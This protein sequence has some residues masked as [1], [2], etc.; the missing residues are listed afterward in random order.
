MKSCSVVP[1]I[2]LLPVLLAI[3]AC[4]EYDVSTA[5]IPKPP[6]TQANPTMA[7]MASFSGDL[8]MPGG[9]SLTLPSYSGFPE[10]VKVTITVSGRVYVWSDTRADYF[11][12]TVNAGPGG[13]WIDGGY[14]QCSVGVHIT[15]GNAGFGP[16]LCNMPTNPPG[17]L[18]YDTS[19]VW[20]FT[21]V[22]YGN[23]SATRTPNIPKYAPPSIC[24]TI[25]CHD[26]V[27]SQSI[28]VV[29]LPGD[30]DLQAYYS[31]EARSARKALFIH[32]FTNSEPWAY[33]QII[34]TDSTT[35]R[36][37][38]MRPISH[39]WTIQDPSVPG[40]AW[41]HTVLTASCIGNAN[42]NPPIAPNAY[43]PTNVKESGTYT[44]TVR[45]NG[46]EHTDEICVQCAT[47][48]GLMDVQRVRDSMIV[49]NLRAN[50]G[51]P[52]SGRVEQVL[53]I[54]EN[55]NTHEIFTIPITTDHA[56][57]CNSAWHVPAVTEVPDTLNILGF[58]HVH[59]GTENGANQI[60]PDGQSAG[61]R[62]GSDK[63]WLAMNTINNRPDYQAAGWRVPF[64]IIANDHV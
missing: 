50:N 40:G 9:S 36:G 46:V 8:Y 18:P 39:T 5:P 35:P 11:Q 53:E 60:C 28:S 33:Q 45:V 6:P 30:L 21:T 41:G 19:G 22:V 4:S 61:T 47:Y 26:Y 23:G 14:Q 24:D 43:C 13:V 34:F 49:L 58:A 31:P 10:G 29:P 52:F 16:P 38:P 64:Y 7:A 51:Q 57:Q 27:G 2:R 54:V 59:P 44:S 1:Q 32:P 17:L 55:R 12:K 42:N 37:L 48:D 20:S 56:D 62:G 25:K 63:D 3:V 15:F